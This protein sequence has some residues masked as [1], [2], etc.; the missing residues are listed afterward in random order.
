MVEKHA[1]IE[2]MTVGRRPAAVYGAS[3]EYLSRKVGRGESGRG[4]GEESERRAPRRVAEIDQGALRF[5][6][7]S[8]TV[9]VVTMSS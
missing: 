1:R 3:C 4:R 2:V 9:H 6:G 5:E 7:D 8:C